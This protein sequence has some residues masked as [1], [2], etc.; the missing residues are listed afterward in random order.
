MC[1]DSFVTQ[2]SE[3]SRPS[4]S[5]EM[6][7]VP[8]TMHSNGSM[9]REI[10]AHLMLSAV[11]LTLMPDKCFAQP[12][13]EIIPE[14]MVACQLLDGV[15]NSKATLKRSVQTQG[16]LTISFSRVALLMTCSAASGVQHA[17][18]RQ[19]RSYCPVWLGETGEVLQK[20]MASLQRRRRVENVLIEIIL[21]PVTSSLSYKYCGADGPKPIGIAAL[22]VIARL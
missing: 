12:K 15:A 5:Q 20:F 1:L 7:S 3:C 2:V 6:Y 22:T 19:N 18:D 8:A 4:P 9:F 10:A 14:Q 21:T 13:A 16:R 11:L 17:V